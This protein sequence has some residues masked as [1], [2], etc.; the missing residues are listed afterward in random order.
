MAKAEKAKADKSGDDSEEEEEWEPVERSE[1]QKKKD[2]E[3]KIAY[4]V[5]IALSAGEQSAPL[6]L[7][8]QRNGPPTQVECEREY[9]SLMAIDWCVYLCHM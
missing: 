2:K 9:K 4:K 8:L 5:G 6:S 7:S 3:D 1:E